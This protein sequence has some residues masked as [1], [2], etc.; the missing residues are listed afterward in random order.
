[1]SGIMPYVEAQSSVDEL[2][3]AQ[4]KRYYWKSLNLRELN[5]P[6]IETIIAQCRNRPSKAT[7]VPIRYLG[8]AISRVGTEETAFGDRSTP[9]LLSIDASWSDL[10][11]SDENIT[12]VREFWK[13][14]LPY[15]DGSAYLNFGG[16]GEDGDSFVQASFGKNYRRLTELKRKYDPQNILRLGAVIRELGRYPE[17]RLLSGKAAEGGLKLRERLGIQPR[18][19]DEEPGHHLRG[20]TL[21]AGGILHELIPNAAIESV[22]ECL[23]VEHPVLAYAVLLV[24]GKLGPNVPFGSSR[25]EN[26]HHQVGSALEMR[27]FH[28]FRARGAIERQVRQKHVAAA[29]LH[30]NNLTVQAS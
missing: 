16:F 13:Q 23:R 7:L 27:G 17:S 11:A 19:Q 10:E 26:L 6:A 5:A 21:L 2:V 24:L 25:A 15:S 8:G 1:M 30:R 22:R 3:P 4:E 20:N 29:E 18:A 12:W 9:I 28:R 14:M